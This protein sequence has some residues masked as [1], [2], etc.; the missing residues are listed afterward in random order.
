VH[1]L[2]IKSLSKQIAGQTI[3][4]GLELAINPREIHA[5]PTIRKSSLA[6]MILGCEGY[7]PTGGEI[8]EL[9]I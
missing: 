3:F 2:E 5:K 9:R 1:L 6:Y 7:I 4:D 8:D